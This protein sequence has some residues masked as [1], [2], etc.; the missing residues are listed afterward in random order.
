MPFPIEPTN[1]KGRVDQGAQDSH[2]AVTT[3]KNVLI[4]LVPRRGWA[5]LRSATSLAEGW[6]S[7]YAAS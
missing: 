7:A 3:T 1:L 2:A 6:K 4:W 5:R